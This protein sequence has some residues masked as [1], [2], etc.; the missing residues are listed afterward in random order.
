MQRGGGGGWTLQGLP[1]HRCCLHSC[2]TVGPQEYGALE[3]SRGLRIRMDGCI[4][5]HKFTA[6]Q[7]SHSSY[8]Q[9]PPHLP[10]H[11]PLLFTCKCRQRRKIWDK[12][13][14]GMA[15]W[16]RSAFCFTLEY[17]DSYELGGKCS[18]GPLSYLPPSWPQFIPQFPGVFV[19]TAS[20]RAALGGWINHMAGRCTK[21]PLQQCVET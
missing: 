12:C 15:M 2:V 17:I 16:Q 1:G 20:V 7:L 6:S 13:I 19:D 9:A 11:Y 4:P 5:C 3:D 14:S 10:Q 18:N 8:T 21:D